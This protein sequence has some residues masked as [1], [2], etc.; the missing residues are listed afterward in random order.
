MD[1]DKEDILI[2]EG[3]AKNYNKNSPKPA[4]IGWEI[5]RNLVRIYFKDLE[6]IDK[7]KFDAE[8]LKS[9]IRIKLRL[10]KYCK[11]GFFKKIK[12]PNFKKRNNG[13][14]EFYYMMD[15]DLIKFGFCKFSDGYDK[16]LIIRLTKEFL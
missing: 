2:F 1:L 6:N 15:L 3:F 5:A 13:E 14:S 11:L 9:Y 7:R 8:L 12:N 10:D 16:S 4:E